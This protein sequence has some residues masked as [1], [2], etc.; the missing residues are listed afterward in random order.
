VTNSPLFEIGIHKGVSFIIA[1]K[2]KIKY[3]VIILSKE[4][5]ISAKKTIKS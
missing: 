3:S 4:V 2:I 1:T 5:K